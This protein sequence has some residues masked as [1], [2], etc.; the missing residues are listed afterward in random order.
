MAED[1]DEDKT[2]SAT[3]RRLDEA[4]K[5][6]Q[7][8]R[9]QEL[10]TFAVLLTGLIALLM[11]G[12]ELFDVL[13]QIFLTELT[14]DRGM[15]HTPEQMMLHFTQATGQAL[16]A[17]LP[18]FFACALAA[19]LTPLL[20]GGWLLSFE[21]LTPNFSRM[22]PLTGITRMFSVRS[23]V[24][25]L[26]AILKSVLI[27]GV[28]AYALWSEKDQFVQ[29]IAMPQDS[30]FAYLWQMS[31]Y[32]LLLVVG[33]MALIPLIDV[34]YQLWDYYKGLRM[35]KEEVKRENKESEGD[36]HIKGRIR[37]LQREAAR[38]RMMANIPKADVIVTNPTHY[39]V[40]LQYTDKM[41]A[42]TVVAKGAYLLA[43]RIIELGREHKVAV[44]RTP[45]F[46]R[47]LYHHAELGEEIPA[48]L[49]TAAAEVLAYIYQLREFQR[50]GGPEPTLNA[51]LPVPAELDPQ[52]IDAS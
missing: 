32:T 43:E 34:P 23:L 31:R 37:Q 22:N 27:G 46:A 49:Y 17:C 16:R 4:R 14:F 41:R 24:E 2:E 19:T 33:G 12:P 20:I 13:R 44:V 11:L 18:I 51:S 35:S 10:S 45:P 25:M 47:A 28:A 40:A 6:G 50:H 29:L 52:A 30:G 26:K 21:P 1:S 9:S 3:P 48:A 8:P 42:P 36:P 7:I 15:L 39:A 5:R 38:K